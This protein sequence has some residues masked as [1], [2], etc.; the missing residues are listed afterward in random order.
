MESRSKRI[1]DVLANEAGLSEASRVQKAAAAAKN[2]A[3]SYVKAMAVLTG[4]ITGW[5]GFVDGDNMT[6]DEKRDALKEDL[7][8]GYFA[9]FPVKRHYEGGGNSFIVYNI[10]RQDA[11][12]LGLRYGQETIVFIDGSHCEYLER[13]SK[14]K[15]ATKQERVIGQRLDMADAA[16]YFMQ[17]CRAFN[18]QI[19]FFDGSDEN[20]EA[21]K[22]HIRYVNEVINKRI[23]DQDEAQRRIE[24]TLVAASGYN[25]YCN[26]GQLYCNNFAWD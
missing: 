14:G 5:N 17:V 20:K 2:A 16:E 15:F 22:E 26:R 4:G 3:S 1:E 7:K 24:T 25:R 21:M 10:S 12:Y 18:P 13:K 23:P 6:D 19:P 11:I 9:W 8:R